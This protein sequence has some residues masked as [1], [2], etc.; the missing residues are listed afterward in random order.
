MGGNPSKQSKGTERGSANEG[1]W[2]GYGH[3]IKGVFDPV[4]PVEVSKELAAL[5]RREAA[6]ND[7][8]VAEMLQRV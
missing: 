6:G 8:V 5:A 1:T 4:R 2:L 7:R 3:P